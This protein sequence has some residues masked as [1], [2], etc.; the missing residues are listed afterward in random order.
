[1]GMVETLQRDGMY[2]SLLERR[3]LSGGGDLK[4][5]NRLY[6]SRD[7]SSLGVQVPLNTLEEYASL[8]PE[9]ILQNFHSLGLI[10]LKTPILNCVDGSHDGVSVYAAAAGLI[11]NINRN[12]KQLSD[13]FE[14]GKS[15]IIASQ[16]LLTHDRQG[17]FQL[18]DDI[19]AGLDEDPAAIGLTIF[20]PELRQQSYLERKQEYLRN[21][22]TLIGFKRG[23]LSEVEAVE[24]TAREITSSEGDY[25]LAIQD[26]QQMWQEAVEEALGVCEALGKLYKLLQGETNFD[27]VKDL[28]IDW[29]DGVLFNRQ[30]V[31]AEYERMV[32][33][34][35]LKPEIALAWYFNLPY[36]TPEE[37]AAIRE[38]Y[39]PEMES[40][41]GG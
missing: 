20:S 33:M 22:E 18:E 23:I 24:R 39:M 27:P 17:R 40:L 5:E 28:I 37:L 4:V 10:H 32:S 29:G 41:M 30:Q 9:F 2:Y 12:E 13:E 11:H 21:V 1:M 3:T 25:N 8:R 6:R 19:F 38:R 35:L 7:N 26:F 36:E 15:R 16:E 31:W 34:G 14:R